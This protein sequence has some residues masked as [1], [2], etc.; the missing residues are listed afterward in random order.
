[1]YTFGCNAVSVAIEYKCEK[2]VGYLQR[3]GFE[4][5]LNKS[6]ESLS[7]YGYGPYE[8]YIDRRIS[9]IK[10]VYKDSV[11]NMEVHYVKPQENGS[12]YGTEWLEIENGKTKIRVE[13]NISFSALPHSSKE[14][15]AAKHDW[16]LPERNSTYLCLDY[17]MAGIGSNSCGPALDEKYCTPMEGEGKFVLILK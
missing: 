7:Y 11:S 9:C 3:I 13:G 10:D 4:A 15:G 17:F 12:H 2:Y 6:F 8:S 5:S 1:M 16:E 14:Y